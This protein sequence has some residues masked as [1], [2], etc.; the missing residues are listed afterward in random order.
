MRYSFFSNDLD[1]IAKELIGFGMEVRRGRE[2]ELVFSN[3]IKEKSY[4]E[5]RGNNVIRKILYDFSLFIVRWWI[6]NR[7][8]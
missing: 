4:L 3:K 6:S 8:G 7:K 5:F 1:K 2:R